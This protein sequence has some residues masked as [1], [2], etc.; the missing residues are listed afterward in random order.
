[1]LLGMP[2]PL[3]SLRSEEK[4]ILS[5]EMSFHATSGPQGS[6]KY[7]CRVRTT[8]HEEECHP[9]EG[10]SPGD[11]MWGCLDTKHKSVDVLKEKMKAQPRNKMQ[12][13]T[14]SM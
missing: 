3:S 14:A 7:E 1:M 11:L 12:P 2:L 13:E 8:E 10:P 5:G 6:D 9:E 4:P